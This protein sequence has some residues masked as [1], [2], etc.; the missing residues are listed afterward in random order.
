MWTWFW[1]VNSWRKKKKKIQKSKWVRKRGKSGLYYPL[2]LEEK[3][4]KSS[5]FL[6]NMLVIISPCLKWMQTQKILRWMFINSMWVRF[7]EWSVR[8]KNYT[9]NNSPSANRDTNHIFKHLDLGSSSFS[10]TL[11]WE[12]N[13]GNSWNLD[14]AQSVV[15]HTM[16]RWNPKTN[17]SEFFS[18]L[19]LWTESSQSQILLLGFLKEKVVGSSP[20]SVLFMRI[21]NIKEGCNCVWHKSVLKLQVL[22]SV[23][24][25]V[26]YTCKSKS[27]S[28]QQDHVY[29]NTIDGFESI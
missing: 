15:A 23:D 17:V 8:K 19:L 24:G 29:H 9:F 14:L 2:L 1:V 20:Y 25:H 12:A 26:Y 11:I 18:R 13:W 16:Q 4:C 21:W 22:N 6:W 27:W 28:L 10:S 3:L 5:P 7:G